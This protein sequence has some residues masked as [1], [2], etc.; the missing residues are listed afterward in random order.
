M[1]N[2]NK[3]YGDLTEYIIEK[4]KSDRPIDFSWMG[5]IPRIYANRIFMY[6]GDICYGIN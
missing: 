2:P 4:S 1:E 3:L 6:G 5:I